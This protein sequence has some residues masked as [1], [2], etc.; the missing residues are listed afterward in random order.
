MKKVSCFILAMAFCL[1]NMLVCLA[2]DIP[3]GLLSE[4]TAMVFYGEVTEVKENSI[5]VMVTENIKGVA[6]P[7]ET[8]SYDEWIFTEIP[9]VG[10]TYLCGYYDDNNPLNIWEIEQRDADN[11]NIIKSDNMSNRMEEYINNGDFAKAQEVLINSNEEVSVE[12]SD[13]IG[14]IGS[15][16]GP[17][18]IVLS[19]S[20]GVSGILILGVAGVAITIA[21]IIALVVIIKAYRKK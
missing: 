21:V 13:S 15:A 14:I 3:E 18:E 6:Q 20:D 8:Y 1:L 7:D 16:D 5:T 19:S 2:G 17:T 11:L 4:E 12:D 10:E 9:V